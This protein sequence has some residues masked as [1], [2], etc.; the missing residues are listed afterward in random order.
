MITER[1]C[2]VAEAAL[3]AKGLID[4]ND[5]GIELTEKGREFVKQ[6]L[7][8]VGLEAKLLIIMYYA[9]AFGEGEESK[10]SNDKGGPCTNE[11]Q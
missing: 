4:A 1:D 6:K 7:T 8:E 5:D 10:E 11:K 3:I 2:M 9:E